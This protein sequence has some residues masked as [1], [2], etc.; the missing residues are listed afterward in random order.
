MPLHP[1]SVIKTPGI[2]AN[3]VQFSFLNIL[4]SFHSHVVKYFPTKVANHCEG[5]P[6]KRSFSG[7]AA[8]IQSF[9]YSMSG[10]NPTR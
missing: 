4:V 9:Q 8:V 2:Q 3:T 6:C 1:E 5:T 7:G 10:V